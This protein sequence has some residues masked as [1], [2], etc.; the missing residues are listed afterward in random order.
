ME[1]QV[2]VYLHRTITTKKVQADSVS[3]KFVAALKVTVDGGTER[4]LTWLKLN[5]SDH[6]K[7]VTPDLITGD[8]DS[9]AEEIIRQFR[10]NNKRLQI[11]KTENQD[12]TDFTKALREI[13]IKNKAENLDVS[14]TLSLMFSVDV[15]LLFQIDTVVAL[16]DTS[17]RLDQIVANI[18]TL[19]KARCIM[20]D[21]K[22]IQMASNS[23]TWLLAEGTHQIHIPQLLRKHDDWCALIPVGN[24]CRVTTTGLKWNLGKIISSYKVD[25]ETSLLFR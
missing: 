15:L 3:Q 2:R 18:N 14:V 19:F 5:N 22:V 16:V 11:I 13:E 8:M 24:P 23:L 1:L 9:V 6:Q 7:N 4:W 25:V 10:L 12:E 17:G 21:V 20:P